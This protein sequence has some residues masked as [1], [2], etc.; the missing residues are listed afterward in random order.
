MIAKS[1]HYTPSKNQLVDAE[2]LLA[3]LF[4]PDSRPSVRW[5]REQQKRRT[6]PFVKISRL[7]R[8]DPEEVR[9]ALRR[10]AG[11]GGTTNGTEKDTHS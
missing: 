1:S 9:A 10:T 4:S 3:A 7:V 2:G 11:T 8:F 6:I 5:V